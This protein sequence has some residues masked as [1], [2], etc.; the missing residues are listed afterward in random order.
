[1]W[2]R[3]S[4]IKIDSPNVFLSLRIDF[5]SMFTVSS[6]D[7]L[8]CNYLKYDALILVARLSLSSALSFM[9]VLHPSILVPSNSSCLKMFSDLKSWIFTAD[10]ALVNELL[11]DSFHV[12]FLACLRLCILSYLLWILS[13][14][15]SLDFSL[16]LFV[17]RA[18]FLLSKVIYL[19]VCLSSSRDF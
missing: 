4:L 5:F 13:K 1:M 2:L 3:N 7:I 18:G 12:N 16:D 17:R 9:F 19:S 11:R 8:E 14:N 6:A 15:D 10:L